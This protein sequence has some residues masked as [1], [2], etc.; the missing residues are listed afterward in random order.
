M[1]NVCK[2]DDILK[3]WKP[4]KPNVQLW[5]PVRGKIGYEEV[6][7]KGVCVEVLSH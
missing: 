5:L 6:Y 2:N 4:G 3:L 7:T 1:S